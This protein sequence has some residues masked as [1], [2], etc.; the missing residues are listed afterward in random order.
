LLESNKV[1]RVEV[2]SI[3]LPKII[4]GWDPFQSITMVYPQPQEKKK[5]YS[6]R[7]ADENGIVDVVLAAIERGASAMNLGPNQA[8]MRAVAKIRKR[9]DLTI[10]PAIYQVPLQLTGKS[11]PL[12]RIDSTIQKYREYIKK[13]S[14]YAEYVSTQEFRSVDTAKPLKNDELKRLKVNKEKFKSLLRLFE[15]K[16]CAKIVTTCIEFYALAD[17]FSLLDDVVK[18]CTDLGF[19]VCAGFHMSNAFDAL[20][21]ENFH[22][23]AYF[24]PLNKV[25]YFMLPSQQHLLDALLKIK[26]PLFV[27]KPLGGGRIMPKEAFDYIFGLKKNAICIVGLSSAQEAHETISAANESLAHTT[28]IQSDQHS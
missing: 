24:A 13:E 8:I 2:G 5:V 12:V 20:E 11:V 19:A 1:S 7:F 25:G 22:F 17:Q 16:G 9:A 14:A 18:T 21:R 4:L 3:D 28:T 23:P 15:N 6:K 27:I 10:I 26:V